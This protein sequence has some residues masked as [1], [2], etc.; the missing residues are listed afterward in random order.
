[1]LVAL[2]KIKKSKILDIK[3]DNKN[4]I[5]FYCCKSV[6]KIYKIILLLF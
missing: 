6:K 1:M 4:I 2:L 5:G 3:M